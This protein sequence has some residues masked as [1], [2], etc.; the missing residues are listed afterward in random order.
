MSVKT[1]KILLIED[2]IE[3]AELIH[4]WLCGQGTDGSFLL[5]W[6][7]SLAAGVKKLETETVDVI[8]LDLS[9]P[10]SKGI[11]TYNRISQAAPGTPVIVLSAGKSESLALAM[12]AQGAAD[13][14]VKSSC[15]DESLKRAIRYALIR[16]TQA[17][18][19]TEGDQ[20]KIIG[21]MGPKG[22]V[23]TSTLAWVLAVDLAKQTGE[24]VLVCDLDADSGLISFFAGL[25]P[26]H[27]L[28]DAVENIGRLDQAF[29]EK[30]VV[31]A[32]HGVDILAS[33]SLHGAGQLDWDGIEKVMARVRGFY[34]WIVVD[35][36]RPTAQSLRAAAMADD[37]LLVTSTGLTALYETKRF[38]GSLDAP[39]RGRFRLVVNEMNSSQG[40]SPDDL[41]NTFGLPVSAVLPHDN[42]LQKASL[43]QRLPADNGAFRKQIVALARNV[44]GL[45]ELKS[46]RGV[47]AFFLR[48][49]EES[50]I[51]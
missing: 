43:E 7:D 46:K 15:N 20:G 4:D 9:L 47:G 19:V 32:P 21:T 42:E 25:K 35:F 39:Q 16:R 13:Y 2:A 41:R 6:T 26:T 3:Y 14:L 22:G 51:A 10:D 45:S 18:R 29:F 24:K 33:P 5:T 40:L 23:G 12:I 31:A 44:A 37:V 27:T 8:L 49:R 11:D 17:E 30:I 28:Q 36:A 48:T 34:K 38:V 50:T 1:L